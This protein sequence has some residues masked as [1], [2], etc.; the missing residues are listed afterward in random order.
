MACATRSAGM[1]IAT[2]RASRTSAEPQRELLERLPCFATRAARTGH[3]KRG[4][5]GN[6]EGVEAAYRRCRR[7]RRAARRARRSGP[8]EKSEYA[9]RRIAEAKPVISSIDSPLARKA[10][11][12]AEICSVVE[13]PL[14]TS[15]IARSASALIE[16]IAARY[17]LSMAWAI[18]VAHPFEVRAVRRGRATE[19]CPCSLGRRC[20][21]PSRNRRKRCIQTNKSWPVHLPVT[22]CDT[23][24]SLPSFPEVP[25]HSL[26]PPA[27]YQ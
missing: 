25:W 27:R 10:I 5:C 23:S 16:A 3:H 12:S 22:L 6:V 8:R 18:A 20:S 19:F 11:R 4:R 17:P 2:P 21:S 13:L 24:R 7:Y 9:W 15:S 1:S 14:R 26:L